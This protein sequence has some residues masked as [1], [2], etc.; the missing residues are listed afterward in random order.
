MD[1]TVVD[2]KNEIE[3]F[4]LNAMIDQGSYINFLDTMA[5]FHKYNLE[6]QINI[7]NNAPQNSVAVASENIWKR[8][9]RTLK[10]N[11]TPIPIIKTDGENERVEYVYD[12]SDTNEYNPNEVLLWHIDEE[13]DKEYLEDQPKN[14]CEIIDFV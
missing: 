11:A 1:K 5:N 12:T 8:L 14:L 13:L 9:G 6:E 3:D 2:L 4:Y 10:N 7:F